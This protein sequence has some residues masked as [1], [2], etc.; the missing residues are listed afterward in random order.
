MAKKPNTATESEEL[1]ALTEVIEAQATEIE[2]LKKKLT[3]S[4]P[5]PAT[6]IS[7]EIDGDT[8]KVLH[9]VQVATDGAPLRLYS[10]IELA[11][12][13]DLVVLLFEQGSTAVSKI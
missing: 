4:A 2:Q 12:N 10:A 7:V 13:H 8:Y 11:E 5:A 9:G 3:T 6:A 1:D